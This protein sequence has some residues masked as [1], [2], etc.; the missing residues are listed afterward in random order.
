MKKKV[1]SKYDPRGLMKI[2]VLFLQPEATEKKTLEKRKNLIKQIKT[3]IDNIHLQNF[4]NNNNYTNEDLLYNYNNCVFDLIEYGLLLMNQKLTT[5]FDDLKIRYDKMN[6]FVIDN[7]NSNDFKIKKK[8]NAYLKALPLLLNELDF[9]SICNTNIHIY[10]HY[11]INLLN[12]A[13]IDAF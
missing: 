13:T 12:L 10:L 8:R 2:S 5:K 11:K 3:Y 9:L 7:Q 4:L 6:K 1:L